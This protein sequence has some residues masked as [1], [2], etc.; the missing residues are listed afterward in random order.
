MEL[1]N[2][3]F[4]VGAHLVFVRC[5]HHLGRCLVVYAFDLILGQLCK[6]RGG[7]MALVPQAAVDVG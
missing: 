5:L 3:V 1:V 2:V 7:L 6:E 4:E